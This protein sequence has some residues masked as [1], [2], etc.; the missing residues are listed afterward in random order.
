MRA[1]GDSEAAQVEEAR[2][3]A[4][5]EAK[6]A[7]LLVDR[8]RRL[9]RHDERRELALTDRPVRAHSIR[10]RVRANAA[11]ANVSRF[12]AAIA[13]RDLGTVGALLT[14][15]YELVD[16]PNGST[17]GRLGVLDY[18]G[19]MLR[20]KSLRFS[21]ELVATLGE[22]LALCRGSLSLDELA[23]DDGVSFGESTYEFYVLI[24]GDADRYRRVEQF[25]IEHLGQAVVRLYERYAE[26][27]PNGHART[28]ATVTFQLSDDVSFRVDEVLVVQPSALV[29]RW[30]TSATDRVGGW[31]VEW[32]FLRLFVLGANG[33]VTHY[34]LFAADQ[35][36]QTLARFDELTVEAVGSLNSPP[37]SPLGKWRIEEEPRAARIEN[38]ATRAVHR[39]THAW[40]VRDLN[41]IAAAMAPGFR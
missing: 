11:A 10:R 17:Y 29:V 24:E 41:S 18:L 23:E 38:S 20:A 26:V 4:L 31:A 27:L 39:A 16:H 30:T 25:A 6:G 35:E 14:D 40:E 12:D 3:V 8:A 15:D 22:S 13:A 2:A 21:H 9:N 19:A 7:T 28:R 36:R 34:E 32:Q 1:A 5:W 37:A 33:L